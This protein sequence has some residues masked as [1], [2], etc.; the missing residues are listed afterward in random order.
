MR[1]AL[2]D[3]GTG[4]SS[5]SY[6]QQFPLDTVKIDR[7][8]VATLGQARGGLAIIR[9]TL[10]MAQA[11]GLRVTA[12]G[13]ETTMQLELLRELGCHYAQGFGLGMPMPAADLEKM[14]RH[15]GRRKATDE[16]P[17]LTLDPPPGRY[18]AL[19]RGN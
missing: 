13:V 14:V 18:S 7:T 8:F 12:E 6:L 1:L 16:R 5:L 3:F 17:I 10:A 9:A 2:D 11:L 15:G 4:Y 19:Q